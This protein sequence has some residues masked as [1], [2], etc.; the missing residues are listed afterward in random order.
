MPLRGSAI[1][2]PLTMFATALALGAP[3]I[4]G[5]SARGYRPPPPPPPPVFRP[6]VVRPPAQRPPV[7]QPPRSRGPSVPPA[8]RSPYGPRRQEQLQQSRQ[9]EQHAAAAR[10]QRQRAA[11]EQRRVSERRTRLRQQRSHERQ[12]AEVRKNAADARSARDAGTVAVLSGVA[13]TT[14]SPELRTRLNALKTGTPGTGMSGAAANMP[15]DFKRGAAKPGTDAATHR[16]PY[17]SGRRAREIVVTKPTRFVRVHA[18]GNQ[19]R[20]WIMRPEDLK[21]RNGR[22]LTPRQIQDKF[23]IPYVPKYISDVHVPANTRLRVGGTA[24]QQGWGAGAGTQYELKDR[25]PDSAFRNK[26]PLE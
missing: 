25:L 26:R 2:L 19:A 7:Y 15:H 8:A 13:P 6:P 22:P 14:L 9:A 3:P 24:P 11:E 1:L 17:D 20:P 16:L 18:E 5:A 10:L 21:D 12:R 4:P 23:A